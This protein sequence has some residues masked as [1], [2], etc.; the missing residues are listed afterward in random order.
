MSVHFQK[1]METLSLKTEKKLFTYQV[2]APRF[3][4]H[5]LVYSSEEKL[6]LGR[7]VSVNIRGKDEVGVILDECS[8]PPKFK[9]KPISYSFDQTVYP[10]ISS[11]RIRWLKW[12]SYYYQYSI[13]L[14][15][16]HCLPPKTGKTKT[17][18][19]LEQNPA[20]GEQD[21][22]SAILKAK[23]PKL[24][25]CQEQCLKEIGNCNK[26]GFRVHLLHGVTGSGKTEVFFRLIEPAILQS[27]SVLVL[28]PEI[29]LTPQHL[30]RF[31]D[32]FPG[33]AVGFHSAMTPAEKRKKWSMLLSGEKRI[34]IGPRSALFCPLP[35]LSW[36]IVDEEHE[37]HFKQEEKF[38][39]H[40]RDSAIYLGKCLDIP[41]VLSS[42]TPSIESWW[43]AKKGKYL[44]HRMSTRVF[45][46]SMPK[47]K[48]VDMRENAK[49]DEKPAYWL[50]KE[51][52]AAIKQ[53]LKQ[54]KQAALFLNRRGESRFTFCAACGYSFVCPN[55]DV[56]LTQHRKLH[57]VCHYCDWR[58]EKPKC[59]PA[60][61]HSPLKSTGLG[62]QSVQN[63]LKELFPK[64]NIVRADRD[65]V[66]SYK[67]WE[68]MVG[69]LEKGEIDILVGTQMIAKGLDFP[70]LNL[71]GL[72]LADQGLSFPDF[73]ASEKCYQLL[74][75]MSGRSGRG[76]KD[77]GEVILQTYN[78]QG[79]IVQLMGNYS[80]FINLELEK[81]K[82]FS[83]PPF[84][85][86]ALVRVQSL[87][88]AQ[89]LKG[90]SHIEASL[91]QTFPRVSILGPAPSSLFRLKN[92]Y[93][94]HLMIKCPD[95]TGDL[96]KIGEFLR[97]M[98]RM[99]KTEVFYNINPVHVV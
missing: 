63:K 52:T 43:N 88:L 38:R 97:E 16:S 92:K 33:L 48:V 23:K 47:C 81:R 42:A 71:V 98:P 26:K 14:V 66:R 20:G 94:Y 5:P 80:A 15:A 10:P 86:L 62:T 85:K 51:L 79:Q 59:C 12:M 40:A 19:Y 18:S 37:S 22:F 27:K 49:E 35:R 69:K 78:P 95:E 74:T 72:I 83:Y 75:Q 7:V 60:C 73:R 58:M 96:Q 50:S 55:C 93:R 21:L 28:V 30:K 84:V 11:Q 61:H 65:E 6:N 44:Y 25:L 9:V 91:K 31:S 34:L 99:R 76:K 39:Y 68:D 29:A 56:S 2:A 36:I 53:C 77:P 8:H 67:E 70:N 24:T 41:V 57:L 89:A 1:I 90:V 32:R 17:S 46:S 64:A 54:R 87:D 13:G 3:L 45:H 82:M 4:N